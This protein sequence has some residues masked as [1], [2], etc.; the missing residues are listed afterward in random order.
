MTPDGTAD[1]RPGAR[2]DA[3]A[4]PVSR[5][6]VEALLGRLDR[7]EVHPL[8]TQVQVLDVVRRGLD[9]ALARPVSDG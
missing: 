6:E 5:T 3:G 8:A 4:T 2:P 9:E 1:A 7:L